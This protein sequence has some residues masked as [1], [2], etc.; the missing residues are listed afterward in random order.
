MQTTST[1]TTGTQRQ[2]IHIPHQ[3]DDGIGSRATM[4]L[5]VL[6]TDQTVENEL[7]LLPL[8]G[9]ALH[10]SRIANEMHINAE[11]LTA[12]LERLPKAAG[13][14]PS[15]FD[16]DVIAYG[17]TSASTLIGDAGVEAAIHEAHPGVAVTNPIRAAVAALGALDATKIGVLTPYSA[18]VTQP[19][20]DRFETDGFTVDSFGSFLVEDDFTVG[21]L[22]P[23]SVLEGLKTVAAEASVD[24]LFVSC[25]SIR[26][27]SDV[28]RFEDELGVPVVSS[29]LALAWHMLRL[30]GI[31]DRFE[32]F[33]SL[34]NL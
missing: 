15:I 20:I 31:D 22:S 27:F 19:V 18:A 12:M 23:A 29:N 6:E 16:F 32:G 5:V 24:A 13:L 3:T 17:C 30:A 4:G 1:Q 14:L 9:V 28:A 8:P 25:T 11:T 26:L 7:R 10:H 2:P 21:R 33:G 34:L